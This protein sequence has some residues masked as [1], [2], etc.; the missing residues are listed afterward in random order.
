M[1]RIIFDHKKEID[2]V[3]FKGQFALYIR[4]RLPASRSDEDI[5]VRYAR[6]IGELPH[7]VQGVSR[8]TEFPT[9]RILDEMNIE[10][11]DAKFKWVDPD[12]ELQNESRERGDDK[13]TKSEI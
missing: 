12:E 3:W 13:G 2:L 6:M 4:R 7:I 11:V 5:F 10:I 9:K 8:G 1:R